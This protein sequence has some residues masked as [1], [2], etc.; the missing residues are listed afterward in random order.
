MLVPVRLVWYHGHKNITASVASRETETNVLYHTTD[1]YVKELCCNERIFVGVINKAQIFYSATKGEIQLAK[2]CDSLPKLLL[3]L[4]H[5]R[6][7][8]GVESW[9]AD[10]AT[11]RVCHHTLDLTVLG[12]QGQLDRFVLHIGSRRGQDGFVTKAVRAIVVTA[13]HIVFHNDYTR[14][15]FLNIGIRKSEIR[16][17]FKYEHHGIPKGTQIERH[18]SVGKV[19]CGVRA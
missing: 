13:A 9:R 12:V 3:F 7:G 4:R 5:G 14:F 15:D 19:K 2:T 8:F 17:A 11:F 1:T 6:L 16:K 10:D 18:V